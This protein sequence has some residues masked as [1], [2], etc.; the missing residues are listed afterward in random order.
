LAKRNLLNKVV[1]FT[2]NNFTLVQFATSLC[3]KC[4]AMFCAPKKFVYKTCS[5]AWA[6]T[7]TTQR[8]RHRKLRH[9]I[10]HTVIATALRGTFL[11]SIKLLIPLPPVQ[12][13]M[14][15]TS[16]FNTAVSASSPEQC[17]RCCRDVGK[18]LCCI[19]NFREE[20]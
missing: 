12:R 8:G 14:E 15:V 7:A 3:T 13:Q 5:S 17:C 11:S 16:S 9:N 6:V 1:G 10:L 4:C 18:H 19:H 20:I 2:G